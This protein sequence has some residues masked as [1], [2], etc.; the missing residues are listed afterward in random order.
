MARTGDDAR[1]QQLPASPAQVKPNRAGIFAKTDGS[2]HIQTDAADS[3]IYPFPALGADFQAFTVPG[4]YTWTKPPGARWIEVW[5]IGGGGGGMGGAVGA[6]ASTRYG[7]GGGSGAAVTR[8]VY[9]TSAL[10]ATETVTVGAGG[11]G[12]ASRGAGVGAGN[13]GADGAISVFAGSILGLNGYGAT[14]I[15]T[16]AETFGLGTGGTAYGTTID[17][18]EP[19]N[20]TFGGGHGC[21]A[22]GGAGGGL[23]TTNVAIAGTPQTGGGSSMGPPGGAVNGGAAPT[24]RAGIPQVGSGGGG[25]AING[26]NGGAGKYGGGGGGGGASATGVNGGAGGN[27]G[28]GAVFV[29]SYR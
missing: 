19:P 5:C 7:G 3:Q 28:D 18:G 24:P 26:G 1:L 20:T 12:G 16:K 6:A 9:P 4:S 11:A 15:G 17:N 10:D 13:V 29:I 23:S 25:G 27:G 22:G 21:A 14:A 8:V 2:V